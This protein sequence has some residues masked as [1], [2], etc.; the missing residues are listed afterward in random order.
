[1]ID[2]CWQLYSRP[3]DEYSYTENDNIEVAKVIFDKANIIKYTK[4][5]L[6]K[7]SNWNRTRLDEAKYRRT[8]HMR[9]EKYVRRGQYL[10]A[11][12]YYH[13]YVF[14]PLVDLLRLTYTPVYADWYLVH[15]SQHIP[16]NER[17]RLE[18]FAQVGSLSDIDER[19][20]LAGQWFDELVVKLEQ[21]NAL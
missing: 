11:Y 1:M 18:Y 15:I 14:E 17:E 6:T 21:A 19:I 9:A 7:Y 20:P 8:Q 16:Q 12:A 4:Q 5:D 13:R 2:F 10:E 3:S